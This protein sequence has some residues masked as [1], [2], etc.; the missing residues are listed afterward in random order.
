MNNPVGLVVF[1]HLFD[2]SQPVRVRCKDGTVHLKMPVYD[3]IHQGVYR[4]AGWVGK[5][6]GT[7]F[8]NTGFLPNYYGPGGLNDGW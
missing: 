3:G 2:V 5:V 8:S 1:E 4:I 6:A 7:P